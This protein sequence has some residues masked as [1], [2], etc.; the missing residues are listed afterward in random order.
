MKFFQDSLTLICKPGET[1]RFEV[2]SVGTFG[3]VKYDL[4]GE[5]GFLPNN[6][7]LEFTFDREQHSRSQLAMTFQFSEPI[8]GEYNLRVIG[9]GGSLASY[10][11]KQQS[12]NPISSLLFGL[13]GDPDTDY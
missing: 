6:E 4:A 9:A 11:I 7:H 12:G 3:G 5:S 10:S 8:G 1:I 13:E 2:D